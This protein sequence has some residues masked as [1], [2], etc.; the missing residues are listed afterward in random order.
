MHLGRSND[1]PVLR[2]LTGAW[3]FSRIAMLVE[4]FLAVFLAEKTAIL[5]AAKNAAF[6]RSGIVETHIIYKPPL[7][8]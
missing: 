3:I 1:T 7:C 6:K 8:I 5:F 2:R 4:L